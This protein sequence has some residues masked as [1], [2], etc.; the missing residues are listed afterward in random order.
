MLLA[1]PG[2]SDQL[3]H[4]AKLK[5]KYHKASTELKLKATNK[6]INRAL[7][8]TPDLEL[9][10]QDDY[11]AH[12]LESLAR[13]AGDCE[14]YAIA[15][16]ITLKWLGVEESQLKLLYAFTDQGPHM[17]LLYG[18]WVLDNLTGQI[19]QL[20][21]RP[22]LTPVFTFNDSGLWVKGQRLAQYGKWLDFQQ[23]GYW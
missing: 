13:G 9:W 20:K 4:W 19:E 18:D 5:V 8:Y 16:L 23:R 22:D 2:H 1:L 14:D 7:R 21:D 6:F 15:K 3:E 17:V 10:G 11:W 12:P